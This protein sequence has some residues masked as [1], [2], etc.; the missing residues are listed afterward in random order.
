ATTGQGTGVFLSWGMVCLLLPPHDMRGLSVAILL[1]L[2]GATAV[3]LRAGDDGQAADR[4][5]EPPQKKRPAPPTL[6]EVAPV[7]SSV[8]TLERPRLHPGLDSL[9]VSEAA[10]PRKT[11]SPPSSLPQ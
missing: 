6:I 7:E 11:G 9:D 5:T 10:R 3:T 1:L 8:E 4:P 2:V